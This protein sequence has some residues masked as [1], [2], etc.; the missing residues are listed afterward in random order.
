MTRVA[1]RP[2]LLRWARERAG[3]MTADDLAPRVPRLAEWEAGTAQPT[4]KQLEDFARAVHVPVGYLF[5]PAP[6][7]E[8]LPIPDFRTHDG[9]GVRRASPNLL[10]M[11][12]VCQERQG[13]YRDFAQAS[14]M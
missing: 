13:W 6:P 10:D 14:R 2:E 11:L 8:P 7:E 12:Y 4:L 1:V 9:R 5:L 3:V